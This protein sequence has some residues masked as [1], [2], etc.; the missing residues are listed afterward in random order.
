MKKGDAVFYYHSVTGKEVVGIA[1]VGKEAYPDKTAD[2]GDW[3]CVDLKP[4]KALK[5]P[6]SLDQLKNDS[7]LKEMKLVRHSRLSVTPVTEK[8][9]QRLLSLSETSL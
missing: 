1:T 9:A 8:E 2:E 3:S 6:V 5:K 4:L 7:V